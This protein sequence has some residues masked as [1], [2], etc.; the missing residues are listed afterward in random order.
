MR[1]NIDKWNYYKGILLKRADEFIDNYV[2]FEPTEYYEPLLKGDIKV[3]KVKKLGYSFNKHGISLWFSGKIPSKKEIEQ[4][5][6]VSETDIEFN[7][8]Y[9]M[10]H[11]RY[12]MGTGTASGAISLN[13]LMDSKH[14][15]VVLDE[16]K[17]KAKELK[18]K[19]EHEQ[20]LL[21]NNH[22]RCTYCNNVVHEDDVVEKVMI[23]RMYNNFKKKFKFCSDQCAM[24]NQMSLEG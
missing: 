23:S 21:N 11:Y 13:E 14:F 1:K 8:D 16:A 7:P 18:E 15:Y 6:E 17:E 4:L 22:I 9:I 2:H 20:H 12:K 19:Y 3:Y 5:K 10:I 24:N